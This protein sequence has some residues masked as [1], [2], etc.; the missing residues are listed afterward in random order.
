MFSQRNEARERK[1][2]IH[3]GKEKA[4]PSFCRQY[5]PIF[6]TTT[7]T[8]RFYKLFLQSSRIHNRYTKISSLYS[9]NKQAKK[10]IG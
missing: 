6:K 9:N 10:E 8:L 1:K 4:K 5:D 3:L 2:E 7:K